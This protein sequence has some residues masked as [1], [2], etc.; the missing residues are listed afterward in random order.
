MMDSQ[1]IYLSREALYQN[2]DQQVKKN[3]V[4]KGHERD[5]I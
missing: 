2:C 3:V 4:S 5:E 1:A